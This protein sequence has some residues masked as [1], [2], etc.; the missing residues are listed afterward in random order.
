MGLR[1]VCRFLGQPRV[2]GNERAAEYLKLM[3]DNVTPNASINARKW[4]IDQIRTRR[5][6]TTTIRNNREE[7][8]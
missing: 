2:G 3:G 8:F 1:L 6:E 5:A 7:E 4:V